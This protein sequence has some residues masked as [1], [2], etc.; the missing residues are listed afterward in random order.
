[1]HIV[2]HIAIKIETVKKKNGRIKIAE[3]ET[4]FDKTIETAKKNLE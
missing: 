3:K 4:L 1:M 2:A